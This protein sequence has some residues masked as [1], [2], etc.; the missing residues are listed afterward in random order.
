M[1][2]N[3][4]SAEQRESYGNYQGE[5]T[6]DMLARYFHLDDFDRQH[7]SSKRGDHNRLGFAVQ[8]CTVRYLGR[9]P[10]LFKN[11]PNAVTEFLAKQ[12]HIDNIKNII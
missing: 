6:K 3:F 12:L 9:F 1:P 10:E 4:L 7:I 11:I 5:P 2:V 8:L